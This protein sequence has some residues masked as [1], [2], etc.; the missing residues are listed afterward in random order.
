MQII[1]FT[2][3]SLQVHVF[4]LGLTTVGKAPTDSLLLIKNKGVLTVQLHD[5]YMVLERGGGGRIYRENL[6]VR[7]RREVGDFEVFTTSSQNR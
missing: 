2:M 1:V 3:P 7:I 5:I 6:V 4:F